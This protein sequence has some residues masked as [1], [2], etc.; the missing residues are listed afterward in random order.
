MLYG[1]RLSVLFGLILTILSS[2]VGVAAGAVQ[3]FYGGWLD[4]LFQRFIEIWAGMPQLYILIIMS[5][6]LVPGFWVLL[7]IL[8]LFSWLALVGVGSGM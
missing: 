2:I 7:G 6:I 1:F 5:S 3:G 4:L 8:L